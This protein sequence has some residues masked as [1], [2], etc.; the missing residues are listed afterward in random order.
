MRADSATRMERARSA[1]A[2]TLLRWFVQALGRTWRI[3]VAEG[4][5]HLDAL[6][7]GGPPAILAFWHERVLLGAY[8]TGRQ[9]AGRGA[10]VTALTSRSGDGELVARVM[11]K[12]GARIVR[13]SSS[14]GGRAAMLRLRGI[15]RRHHSSPIMVPDGPR[16]PARELKR[17]ILVLA[18]ISGVSVLAMGLAADRFWRLN[19]WD[20]MV[21]PQPFARVCVCVRRFETGRDG[22]ED[23]GT[24][25]RDGL[26][27]M[28]NEVTR[29][30]DAAVAIGATP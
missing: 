10:D 19:S 17:G 30:A 24:A 18:R 23:T 20:G 4:Q 8:Y 21:V 22:D 29:R 3:Q 5:E 14:A 27:S 15:V 25:D 26:Q 1:L 28:L 12:W 13:G 2:T 11:S 16:G 9:M 6:L 7:A